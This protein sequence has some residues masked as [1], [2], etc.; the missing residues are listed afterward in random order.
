MVSPVSHKITNTHKI[1]CIVSTIHVHLYIHTQ[2][3]AERSLC[4]YYAHVHSYETPHIY[5]AH[6][7]VNVCVHGYMR[8][9][10]HG[11]HPIVLALRLL[12]AWADDLLTGVGRALCG[13][14]LAGPLGPPLSHLI[15]GVPLSLPGLHFFGAFSLSRFSGQVRTETMDMVS[16]R[17]T[18]NS[19]PTGYWAWR[20]V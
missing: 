5:Y 17:G 13:R 12:V 15:P 16:A 1:T 6:R 20:G 19:A 8:V 11:L 2:M 7:Y 10:T 3:R 14:S 18:W 4:T 9:I